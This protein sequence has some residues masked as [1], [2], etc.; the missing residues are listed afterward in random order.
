[1]IKP[2]VVALTLSASASIALPFSVPTQVAQSEYTLP[3]NLA[4][5]AAITAIHACEAKGWPVSVFVVDTSGVIRVHS[6]GRSQHHS[7]EG[8]CIP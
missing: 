8:L 4:L 2:V 6:Q 1:M 5:K 7:H 3:L